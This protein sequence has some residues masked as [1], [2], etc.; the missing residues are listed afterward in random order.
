MTCHDFR[1]YRFVP[2]L[3]FY[4]RAGWIGE[5]TVYFKLV[6]KS[7][8]FIIQFSLDCDFDVLIFM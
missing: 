7:M 8:I 2:N 6:N 3:Q 4:F 1:L 5:N